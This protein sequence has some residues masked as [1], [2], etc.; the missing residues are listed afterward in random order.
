MCVKNS[1]NREA[2]KKNHTTGSRS[3][4]AHYESLVSF[5]RSYKTILLESLLQ[6]MLTDVLNSKCFAEL[7]EHGGG[8][9]S[10]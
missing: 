1:V 6:I 10:N 2:V 8:D 3:F 7:G 9:I 4:V 5:S